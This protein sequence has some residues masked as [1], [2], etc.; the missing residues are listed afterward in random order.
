MKLHNAI[1]TFLLLLSIS[2]GNAQEQQF[3]VVATASMI[4]DIATMIGGDQLDIE[5]IVP[6]GGDPHL[7][8]P[9]PRDAQL[10]SKAD[11]VLKNGLTFE[12]WLNELIENSGTKARVVLV[13]EGVNVITSDK[14]KDSTDPHAWMDAANGI[15]Y[16]ENIAAAF[17]KL[18]P[19]NK[20]IYQFNL[21][22]YTQQLADLDNYITEAIAS[23][24]E[25]RRVLITSH[26]A[27]KYYGR[28]YGLRLEAIL[29]TSTDAD[30][31]TSDIRRLNQVI[32]ESGVPAV[33]IEST[34]NPK[35]LRQLAEDNDIRIGGELYADSIGD[36]DS[37]APSYYDMLKYNTDTIV[38]AL[39]QEKETVAAEMDQESGSTRY[40]LIGII[41]AL[42]IG[43]FFFVARQLN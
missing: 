16:A 36:E 43:G 5:C 23:I 34:V 13:T 38:K 29:G 32:R 37:P 41:A 12:G 4:A 14:Y 27:F 35:L 9:T 15:K 8:E 17:A 22:V 40:L 33:F 42:L 28:K 2:I 31:Q 11:L 6:I 10:V 26:D 19:A 20:E 7:H 24:P 21:G 39:T 30:A 3:K 1:L 25:A 18:D